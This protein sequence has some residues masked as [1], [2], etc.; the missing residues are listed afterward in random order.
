M[1]LLEREIFKFKA[2]QHSDLISRLSFYTC[3][4][5]IFKM[6]DYMG[7]MSWI[8]A[9]LLYPIVAFLY[10]GIYFLIYKLRYRKHK[11][12]YKI[13]YQ[14]RKI[15]DN[16]LDEEYKNGKILVI[17]KFNH[18]DIERYKVFP[19]NKPD[20]VALI[21]NKKEE[22]EIFKYFKEK[23]YKVIEKEFMYKSFIKKM[24]KSRYK[25]FYSKDVKKLL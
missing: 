5:Y 20:T 2:K 25:I 14:I 3:L 8:G 18:N 23:G 10:L 15:S 24:Y 22:V 1:E 9:I 21:F 17:E 19:K 16:T 6:N 11:E 13:D 4:I 12:L 7:T